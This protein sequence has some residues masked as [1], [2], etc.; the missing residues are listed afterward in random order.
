[1]C[2]VCSGQDRGQCIEKQ[3]VSEDQQS[4]VKVSLRAQSVLQLHGCPDFSDRD[5]GMTG[6]QAQ[7]TLAKIHAFETK[8]QGVTI[9][10]EKDGQ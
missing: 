1:M 6:S 8:E 7:A 2:P 9:K 4:E 5:S 3:Q 10:S